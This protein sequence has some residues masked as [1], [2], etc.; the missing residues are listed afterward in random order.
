MSPV[1]FLVLWNPAAYPDAYD[2]PSP[3]PQTLPSTLVPTISTP[4]PEI[5]ETK[6]NQ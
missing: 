3:L 6:A 5:G 1:F 4:V 2:A